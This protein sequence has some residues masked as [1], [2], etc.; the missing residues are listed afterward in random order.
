VP[1]QPSFAFPPISVHFCLP[2]PTRK[3]AYL[4]DIYVLGRAAFCTTNDDGNS[5]KG[6]LES[7]NISKVCF[8]IRNDSDALFSHY[9]ISVDCIKYLQLMEL[10]TRNFS[11]TFLAKL[12]KCIENDSTVSD[13]TKSE[14]KRTKDNIGRLYALENDGRYRIFDERPIKAEIVQYCARDV[15]L[16]P[17]LWN[18]YGAKLRPV[19][20]AFWRVMQRRA[21]NERIKVSQSVNYNPQAGNKAYG[22]WDQGR[23]ESDTDDWNNDVILMVQV[24][25]VLNKDDC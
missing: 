4:V 14:W 11:R 6:I 22:P 19:G 2:E 3:K 13:A 15:A 25:M 21:T 18:V 9:Q 7:R 12:A 16:F 20:D 8:D 1:A 10:A 5:L 17:E 24:G 23:I